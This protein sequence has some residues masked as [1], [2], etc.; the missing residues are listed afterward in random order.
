M[1]RVI[2]KLN[3]VK[4][5]LKD[6]IVDLTVSNRKLKEIVSECKDN[7][8]TRLIEENYK[9]NEAIIEDSKIDIFEINDAI[10]IL[11]LS[12]NMKKVNKKRP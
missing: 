12:I 11:T 2:E 6:L 9:D 4:V 7:F 5:E 10:E 8:E 3:L 1:E